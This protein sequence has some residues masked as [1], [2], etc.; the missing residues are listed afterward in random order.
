MRT[1]LTPIAAAIMLA[2]GPAPAA[3]ETR[4]EWDLGVAELRTMVE[5][6]QAEM[7][8]PGER[9]ANW[10]RGG[11]DP[12]AELRAA[13]AET[14]YYH[15]R[16]ASDHGVAILT[17]RPIA[18]F[19]PASWRVV[20]TYGSATAEVDNPIVQFDALSPRYVAGLRAGSERRGDVDCVDSIAN[21]I[22]FERTDVPAGAEDA[23]IPLM[24]RLFLIAAEGQ[25]VC[26]RYQGNREDGYRG[27]AFLPDG[28][29]LPV[30]NE[31]DELI[32]IVPAA[33]LDE[34]V[35]FVGREGGT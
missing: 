35:T 26:T 21:A 1:A 31:S 7:Y 27:I 10:N 30:L 22:L 12:D 11:A 18:G 24:F 32:T 17:D 34:L 19:A 28:R 20:D 3:Q 29:T 8:R 16:R 4:G 23:D 5:R 2:A 9:V 13:G 15:L 25:T 14:H 6:I 33:P